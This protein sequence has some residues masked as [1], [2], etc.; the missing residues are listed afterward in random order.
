MANT[1]HGVTVSQ[2]YVHFETTNQS[3]LLSAR[4]LDDDGTDTGRVSVVSEDNKI[5]KFYGS[6]WATNDPTRMLFSIKAVSYGRTRFKIASKT[7]PTKYTYLTVDVG[8]VSNVRDVRLSKSSVYLVTGGRSEQVTATVDA[9]SGSRG[10]SITYSNDNIARV[11]LSATSDPSV[12]ALTIEAL[13]VGETVVTVRSA[14]DTTRYAKLNVKVVADEED[15]PS[16]GGDDGGSSG[17]WTPRDAYDQTPLRTTATFFEELGED[18]EINDITSVGNT[19][20]IS[21]PKN[22][23]YYLWKEGAYHFLGNKIPAPV[24]YF[25]EAS[26][27][28]IRDEIPDPLVPNRVDFPHFFDA[29]G[30]FVAWDYHLAVVGFAMSEYV[31]QSFSHEHPKNN[32]L[33]PAKWGSRADEYKLTNQFQ[34]YVLDTVWGEIDDI[35][36][37][38]A[39]SGKAIFPVFV[40]YAVRLYDGTVYAQSIPVLVGADLLKYIRVRTGVFGGRIP[41]GLTVETNGD[42]FDSDDFYVFVPVYKKEGIPQDSAWETVNE[43][44]NFVQMR[45]GL[46]EAYSLCADFS[47][48]AGR[49][50]G[51]DDIV[52]GVDIYIS[53]QIGPQLRNAAKMS[54]VDGFYAEDHSDDKDDFIGLYDLIIDPKYTEVNQEKSVLLHQQTYLAKS[55]TLDEFRSLSGEVILDD[56]N[57]SSDHIMAQEALKETPQSM[58]YTRGE[59]LFNYNNRL[60]MTNVEQV[61]HHGYQFL[62][63]VE[64]KNDGSPAPSYR[65]VYHLHGENGESVVISRDENGQGLIIPKQRAVV[66]GSPT[67]YTESPVAWF[68]YPDSRCYRIDV[69]QNFGSTVLFSSFATKTFDQADVAYVFLGFGVPFQGEQ[70]TDILPTDEN[71][72]YRMPNSLVVSRPNNPFVFPAEDVVTFIA[73][74]ILNIAVASVPLSEGQAGQFPLYVFTDEGVFAMTVDAEGKLRTSHNVSRDILLSKDALVGIEQGVFFAAARGLLLLQGSRVTNVSSQM[75]GLPTTMDESLLGKIE[76]LLGFQVDD[77]QALRSFLSDCILAYDYA[78]TRIL[79][80]NPKYNAMYVYKFDTQSWHR[81]QTDFGKPVRVLNAFPEAQIAMRSGQYQ[82]LL[83]FSVLAENENAEAMRGL[84]YTRDLDLDGADIYKVISKLKV[85]GRFENGHVRWQLQGSNDGINYTTI[86]SLHGPSWKWY[87][88]ALFT[89]LGKNE[90]ISYIEVDYNPKFTDAIR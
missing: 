48:N 36:N 85:R 49:F 21:T 20:I 82:S 34:Q 53:T 57:F 15:V 88:I 40:R 76:T 9:T 79:V 64:W 67:L 6:S 4:V 65:F 30:Q 8:P 11:T 56:I 80:A 41:A 75:D 46:P 13:R 14:S 84:V 50:D 32:P 73:G 1:I 69:Y 12:T 47:Y 26:L 43:F 68:A 45:M 87:R 77:Q 7:D 29:N 81:M 70:Y 62:H 71:P 19:L 61:L 52:S 31:V 51:W 86:H 90:R 25:R 74:E 35:V 44:S 5:A 18:E 37:E 66:S 28:A 27:D 55:Y 59:N 63:S 42:T 89:M 17:E 39:N 16:G 54:V 33:H 78:N 38:K 3:L 60:M 83:D 2:E 23:Y 72:V 10:V 24:I 58:H 22:M